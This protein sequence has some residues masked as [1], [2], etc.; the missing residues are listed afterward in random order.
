MRPG[1][2]L[3]LQVGDLD[4]DCLWVRRRLY[5]GTLYTPKNELS[6]RQVALTEGTMIL[7][8]QWVDSSGT[9]EK[10]AWLFPSEN[11]RQPLRRDNVWYRCI[12]PKL[13]PLGLNWATFQVMRRTFASWSKGQALMLIR[14]RRK[15]AIPWM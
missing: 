6:A 15:W 11:G 2:V 9:G 10:E 12:L 3:A 4:R 7:L 8:Q 1:E 13:K 5:K 14:G